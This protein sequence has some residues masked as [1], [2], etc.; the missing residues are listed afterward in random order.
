M[1]FFYFVAF[2]KC[3]ESPLQNL[4]QLKVNFRTQRELHDSK[5]PKSILEKSSQVDK[6]SSDN[7]IQAAGKS[8]NSQLGKGC[9][10]KKRQTVEKPSKTCMEKRPDS[11]KDKSKK[12]SQTVEKPSKTCVEKGPDSKKVESTK[13]SV[14]GYME[15]SYAEKKVEVIFEFIRSPTNNLYVMFLRYTIK[16]FDEILIFLQAE[17]PR[18]HTVR[19]SLHRLLRNILVRF[20][21]P[22]ALTGKAA[23]QVDYHSKYNLKNNADIV[24]GEEAKQ[25]I[26]NKSENQSN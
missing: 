25:F 18:I 16:V 21:K 15:Q 19:R 20:V 12:K 14:G 10:T 11:K 1:F 22:S 17:D 3:I 8:G 26:A 23:D 9:T 13:I 6:L 24:I 5:K 7:T 2:F 4:D